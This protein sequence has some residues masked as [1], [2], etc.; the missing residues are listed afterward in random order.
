MVQAGGPGSLDKARSIESMSKATLGKSAI[1][2]AP[3]VA[4]WAPCPV[5]TNA[6]SGETL[7]TLLGTEKTG[8]AV[9]SIT[10]KDR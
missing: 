3:I 7:G 5:N 8:C 4:H 9:P 2:E 10:A 1:S 6:I